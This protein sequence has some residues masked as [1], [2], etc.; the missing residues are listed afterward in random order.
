MLVTQFVPAGFRLT[1]PV[2]EY[3]RD[4][5]VLQAEF[6]R[7]LQH[8]LVGK[9]AIHPSQIPIIH[10]ALKVDS[11]D[12]EAAKR[13]LEDS[14]PAV[15]EFEGAMCEP[16]THHHW[17]VQVMERAKHFGCHLYAT[18]PLPEAVRLVENL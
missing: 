17:A 2:F 16:A 6:Q 12:Y 15:F 1:A 13:I 4:H 11:V 9:T 14:S 3:F 18:L 5:E 8:G 7:D 10:Q